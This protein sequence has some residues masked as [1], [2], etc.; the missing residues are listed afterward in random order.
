M[1]FESPIGKLMMEKNLRNRLISPKHSFMATLL[2]QEIR[3]EDTP[4]R[5]Y[6]NILPQAYD[7]FPIFY[8]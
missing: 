1:A 7:N 3:K 4:H 8:T 2:M 6:L 5:Q